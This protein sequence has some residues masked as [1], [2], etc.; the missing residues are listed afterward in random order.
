MC[1]RD[2]ICILKNI[3]PS[4][5]LG[6]GTT[7]PP[8]E[9]KGTPFQGLKLPDQQVTVRAA[10]LKDQRTYRPMDV[11]VLVSRC[12]DIGESLLVLRCGCPR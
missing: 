7:V 9:L 3:S 11:E 8:G 10:Y 6:T 12:D 1:G 4:V 5:V 2:F